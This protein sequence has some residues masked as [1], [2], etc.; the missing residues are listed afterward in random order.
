MNDDELTARQRYE[1]RYGPR[2]D[3]GTDDDEQDGPDDWGQG[4][5]Q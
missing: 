1:S 2:Q 4:R 5:Y 3:C